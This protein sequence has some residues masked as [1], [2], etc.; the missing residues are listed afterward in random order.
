M[1]RHLERLLEE[2]ASKPQAR[3]SELERLS[4][5]EREQILVEWNNTGAEY[6]R[7][8]C[9]HELFEEQVE[10]N[11]EAVA[12]VYEGKQ[13]SYRELNERSNQLAHQLQKLGVGPEM[14]VGLY[15]ER[16][17]EI[18]VGLLGIVKAGGA[19]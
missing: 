8:K 9:L 6:P 10:R 2:M 16:S 11:P 7:E 13:L 1:A 4:E 18:V 17:L 15:L 19:Y 3:L 12:V 14:L 5:A